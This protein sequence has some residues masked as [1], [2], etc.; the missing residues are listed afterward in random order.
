MSLPPRI[1]I[2]DLFADPAVSGVTVSPD[3][4]RIGF[5]APRNGR[6]QVWVAPLEDVL[7]DGIDLDRA[8]CL[9][10][11]RARGIPRYSWVKGT[12]WLLYEQDGGGDEAWHIHRVDLEDPGSP[13]VDL[14]PMG[15][16][17]RAV[18]LVVQAPADGAPEAGATALVSMNWPRVAHMDAHLL[19]L[20]TGE[21][22]LV[23]ENPGH[24]AGWLFS[25]R[26]HV[27]ALAEDA[28]HDHV[29]AVLEPD[30][31][32]G[33]AQ[34]EPTPDGTGAWVGTYGDGDH[35]RL[36]RL[37]LATG[38]E[39][40]VAERPGQDLD[41]NLIMLQEG[42]ATLRDAATGEVVAARFVGDRPV[43]EIVDPAF[44]AVAEHLSTLHDGVLTGASS[45]ASGRYWVASFTHDTDPGAAF[46]YD[47]ETGAARQVADPYPQLDR[48]ALAPMTPVRIT[49]RDGLTL[50]S[51]LTLPVGVPAEGLPMVLLVHGGPWYRDPWGFNP[52][53]QFFAN[54]GY[55]VLQ[56]NFRGSIGYGRAHTTAAIG[57]MAGKMH[58]DLVDAVEWAVKQGYADPSRVAIYGGS[59][60]G[61]AALVGATFTP[62]VFACAIDYV[63]V[64]SLVNFQRTLPPFVRDK[65]HNNW[66]RYVGD[67]DIPEQHADML[68]RSPITRLDDL[69]IP[70]L[71]IQ[72]ANDVRVVKAESDNVVER[73]RARGVDVEYIVKDDEGHGFKNPENVVDMF[74][75]VERFLAAHLAPA[76]A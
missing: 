11:D 12:S 13:A 15:P 56:V 14:T 57:E 26:G 36:A 30:S 73:L 71:V 37:D 48:A 2:E 38:E 33:V 59:Y 52:Q 42:T 24:V 51:L 22:T 17:S 54:R 6:K 62:D 25:P 76:P 43:L 1:P 31:P 60:G 55:A 45:D 23:A 63:G 66:G 8:T 44:A 27:V 39:T 19:D 68:A 65:L 7:R 46:L 69:V 28:D 35:L 67:P 74:R 75:S 53:V 20:A 9:T 29:I 16:G 40:V 47:R 21:L 3:G 41:L 4:E 34:L 61:Y 32:L 58:D 49:S 50:P 10:D 5:L 70:L 72:G 18:G 64:S